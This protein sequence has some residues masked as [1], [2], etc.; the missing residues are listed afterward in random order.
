M[1]GRWQ[2]LQS[3]PQTPGAEMAG[4]PDACTYPVHTEGGIP[5]QSNP[6]DTNAKSYDSPPIC[7]EY[8]VHG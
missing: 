1:D 6:A 4:S 5:P 2:G 8:G 3:G 7:M